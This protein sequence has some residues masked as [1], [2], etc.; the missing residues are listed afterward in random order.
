[1][2]DKLDFIQE[3]YEELSL[4]VSD[5]DV[6]AD[7]A[8][9]QK[10]AKE[11][12]EMEPIVQKYTEYKKAVEGIQEAKDILADGMRELAKME[13]SDLEESKEKL[14]DELRILLIPKDPNDQKNVILEIR[15]GTGGDEAAL[16]G[17]DLEKTI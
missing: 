14:E 7:Q 5:P 13:L 16:F 9:W 6:I 2:Y 4:K 12:G 1:M 10:Y 8:N 15:A 3:K 17:A 11:L